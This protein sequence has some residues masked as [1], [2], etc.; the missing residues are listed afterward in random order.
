MDIPV[1]LAEMKRVLKPGGLL[2]II[3]V[4]TSPIWETKPFQFFAKV[5]AF[6]F[7]LIREN[8]TRAWAEAAAVSN[9][10]TPQGWQNDLSQAGFKKVEI[11]KLKSKYGWAPEP[12]SIQSSISLENHS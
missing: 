6:L 7:F 5:I 4:G 12:L 1:M 3:D 9:L 10:R 11:I 2:S 8:S